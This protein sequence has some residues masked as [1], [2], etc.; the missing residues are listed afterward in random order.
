MQDKSEVTIGYHAI[1]GYRLYNPMTQSVVISRD[2]LV[3]EEEVWDWE[4]GVA[5]TRTVTEQ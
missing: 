1:G 2:V 3:K 4:T 5:K